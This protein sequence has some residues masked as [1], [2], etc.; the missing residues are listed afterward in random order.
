MYSIPYDTSIRQVEGVGPDSVS[1]E[2]RV[3]RDRQILILH[4]QNY[5]SGMFL[6]SS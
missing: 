2:Q 6:F 3:L 5:V 4:G 1:V